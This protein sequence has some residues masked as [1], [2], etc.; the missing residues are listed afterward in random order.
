[1]VGHGCKIRRA[2]LCNVLEFVA[3]DPGS[4]SYV[5]L[6]YFFSPKRAYTFPCKLEDC[7][8][9]SKNVIMINFFILQQARSY[10]QGCRLCFKRFQ[11]SIQDG[12]SCIWALSSK[13]TPNTKHW[14]FDVPTHDVCCTHPK[15]GECRSTT[16]RDI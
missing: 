13:T 3:C 5:Q 6:V 16:F 8:G 15:R 4:Q 1:M 7:H 9:G 10:F 11:L 2:F 14:E 12:W